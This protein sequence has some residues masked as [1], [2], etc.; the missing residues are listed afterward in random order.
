MLRLNSPFRDRLQIQI[1][2]WAFVLRSSARPRMDGA[3]WWDGDG[4]LDFFHEEYAARHDGRALPCV[5]GVDRRCSL[6]CVGYADHLSAHVVRAC[7]SKPAFHAVSQRDRIFF[8]VYPFRKDHRGRHWEER[9]GLQLLQV[10]RRFDSK[11]Y[12]RGLSVAVA[13]LPFSA[14]PLGVLSCLQCAVWHDHTDLA[15]HSQV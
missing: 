15:A 5:D 4:V 1:T 13:I 7:L 8:R 2:P 11:V 14:A 3:V 10:P 9:I 6:G 12:D